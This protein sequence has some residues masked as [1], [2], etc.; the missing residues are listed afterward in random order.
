MGIPLPPPWVLMSLVLGFAG[1]LQDFKE[2]AGLGVSI[3]TG[4]GEDDDQVIRHRLDKA[5][6]EMSH[7]GD[8]DYLV[9]N[10]EFE[11]ALADLG[12]IVRAERLRRGR[13]EAD[14]APL[15]QDLL[16]ESP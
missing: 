11:H 16:R 6:W 1:H 15:L 12:C 4:R 8:Y 14:L 3:V 13:Q 10:D 2:L 5:R 7:Y 9:V